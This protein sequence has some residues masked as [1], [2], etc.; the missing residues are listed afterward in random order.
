[1]QKPPV[2]DRRLFCLRGSDAAE[3]HQNDDQA[4]RNAQQPQ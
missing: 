2:V 1:M 3:Q 4:E